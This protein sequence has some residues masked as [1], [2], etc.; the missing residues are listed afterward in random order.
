MFFYRD[1]KSGSSFFMKDPD[2]NRL[3][4]KHLENHF[5]LKFIEVNSD[6]PV[7]KRQAG[8]ELEICE[9]KL[10][11]WSRYP[12]FDKSRME[13]DIAELKKQWKSR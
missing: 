11:F 1:D 9:R 6:S 7:E 12:G 3:Y 10:K 8:I 2:P 13:H 5:F 4:R